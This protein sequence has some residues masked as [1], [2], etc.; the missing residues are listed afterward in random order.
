MD[1]HISMHMRAILGTN[2][3]RFVFTHHLVYINIKVQR[4]SE[5]MDVHMCINEHTRALVR[6]Y[7]H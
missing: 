1:M 4:A 5:I 6:A 2:D 7:V 3:K